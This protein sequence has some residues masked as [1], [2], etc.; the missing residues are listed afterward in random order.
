M[1]KTVGMF[2]ALWIALGMLS[3]CGQPRDP[4]ANNTASNT[5]SQYDAPD[6]NQ[7]ANQQEPNANAVTNQPMTQPRV[8]SVGA[9]DAKRGKSLKGGIITA[10]LYARFSVEH[11]MIFANVKKALDLYKAT[12]G[13]FPKSHEEFIDEIIKPNG[14]KL[15]ELDPGWEYFFDAEDGQLKKRST[16]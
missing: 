12:N 11:K 15:P 4:I 16:Q 9:D 2:A 5:N 7:G 14:I 10:P 6:N 8:E 13:H 3:G 1:T